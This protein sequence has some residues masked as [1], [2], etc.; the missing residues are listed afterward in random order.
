VVLARTF[1]VR[2]FLEAHQAGEAF[3]S[4]V[5]DGN[6]MS[7]EVFF[8][9]QAVL[10]VA[11]EDIGLGKGARVGGREQFVLGKFFEA[12]ESLSALKEG[13]AAGMEELLGLDDEFDFAN[14][15][16]AKFDVAFEFA[17]SDDFGF[18]AVLHGDDFAQE[19]CI[20]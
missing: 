12:R 18:D 9:L 2:K 16:T 11:K 6:G 3:L 5:S 13:L 14:A 1:E 19:V 10:D 8:H 4:G 20:E 7:L 17:G 15:T